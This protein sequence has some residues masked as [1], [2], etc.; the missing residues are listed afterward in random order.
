MYHVINI[1]THYHGEIIEKNKKTAHAIAGHRII[2]S[3]DQ[4]S[5]L[6]S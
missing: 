2:G 5:V 4:I 3:F 6:F 1:Q